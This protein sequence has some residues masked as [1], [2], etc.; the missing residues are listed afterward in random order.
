[1]LPGMFDVTRSE[2]Q[3]LKIGFFANRRK[4]VVWGGCWF[5]GEG[6]SP[7]LVKKWQEILAILGLLG[8]LDIKISH[9]HTCFVPH[10]LI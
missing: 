5:H 4:W 6:Q 3:N 9:R 8:P 7:C 1:M 10:K 2:R